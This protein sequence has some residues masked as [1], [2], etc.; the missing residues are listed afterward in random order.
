MGNQTE[1][2]EA[3]HNQFETYGETVPQAAPTLNGWGLTALAIT[4]AILAAVNIRKR[5]V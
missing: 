3:I 1:L 5:M 2:L 4:V